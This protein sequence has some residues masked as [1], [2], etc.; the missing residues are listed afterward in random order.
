MELQLP[1]GASGDAIEIMLNV[2]GDGLS[3]FGLSVRATAERAEQTTV[4]YSS[5]GLELNG[6]SA[7]P[8]ASACT[9]WLCR[10]NDFF[11]P[12]LTDTVQARTLRVFVDKSV[13]EAHLDAR[14]SITSRAYPPASTKATTAWL[15]NQGAGDLTADSVSVWGM[16]STWTNVELSKTMALKSASRATLCLRRTAPSPASNSTTSV[17]ARRAYG[18]EFVGQGWFNGGFNHHIVGQGTKAYAQYFKVPEPD[19]TRRQA[20]NLGGV[21][22]EWGHRGMN[23]V[24]FQGQIQP[25]FGKGQGHT[26]EDVKIYLDECAANGVYVL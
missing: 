22:A 25:R 8:M 20:L 23:F 11:A 3:G 1:A 26:L 24:R 18:I 19:Y 14:L 17:A 21:A 7:D 10:C 12:P 6:T 9:C 5:K 16:S 2:S 4:Y 13:I 15:I